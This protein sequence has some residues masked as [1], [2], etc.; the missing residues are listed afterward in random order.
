MT[1]IRNKI[2]S[3]RTNP[4]KETEAHAIIY[5]EDTPRRRCCDERFEKYLEGEVRKKCI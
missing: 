5:L 1:L 4:V 3:K 2:F